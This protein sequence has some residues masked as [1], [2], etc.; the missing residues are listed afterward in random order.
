MKT[1]KSFSKKF[2]WNWALSD[3]KHARCHF[4]VT[5]LVDHTESASCKV[6]SA[7]HGTI[8]EASVHSA[9]NTL[10]SHHYMHTLLVSA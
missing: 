7:G 8:R 2:F 4:T 10:Y 6:G 9:E 3:S 1:E 5:N